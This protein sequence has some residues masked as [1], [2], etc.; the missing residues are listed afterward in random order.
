[1]Y[2]RLNRVKRDRDRQDAVDAQKPAKQ[3]QGT[4]HEAKKSQT[5]LRKASDG[6]KKIVA[7][8]AVADGS[9]ERLPLRNAD[10]NIDL[11][12]LN[13]TQESASQ[14]SSLG[15]GPD[16]LQSNQK[17]NQKAASYQK[18]INIQNANVNY[19]QPAAIQIKTHQGGSTGL[20]QLS[21]IRNNSNDIA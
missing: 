3:S 18:S 8:E 19:R 1:M 2:R 16:Y 13:V 20:T 7:A 12:Q 11:Q 6:T 14:E 5:N 4:K 10:P 15:R 9:L 21:K 17:L